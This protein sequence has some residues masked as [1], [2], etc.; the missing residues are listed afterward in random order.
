MLT[1]TQ[2]HKTYEKYHDLVITGMR[3]KEFNQKYRR[4][5]DKKQCNYYG[6]N[7]I[8]ILEILIFDAY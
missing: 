5:R 7:K 1:E 4:K 6:L 8:W 3:V 2:I